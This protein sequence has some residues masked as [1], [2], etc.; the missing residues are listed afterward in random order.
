[1]DQSCYRFLCISSLSQLLYLKAMSCSA[2][3]SPSLLCAKYFLDTLGISQCYSPNL[4]YP[5]RPMC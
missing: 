4:K 2:L 3:P 5:Q 1:M